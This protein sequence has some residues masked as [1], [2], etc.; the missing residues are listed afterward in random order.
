MTA[1][2]PQDAAD[3]GGPAWLDGFKSLTRPMGCWVIYLCTMFAVHQV[4]WLARHQLP[5]AFETVSAI[6]GFLGAGWAHVYQ[7]TWARTRE[8][9]DDAA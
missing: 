9:R 4:F 1:P 7:Y 5:I 8:K 6:I 3:V 2:T